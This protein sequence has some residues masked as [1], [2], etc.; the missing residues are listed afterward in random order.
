MRHHYFIAGIRSMKFK[1][2]YV[3]ALLIILALVV[4]VLMG[5]SYFLNQVKVKITEKIREMNHTGFRV[6]YD[7]MFINWKKN[8]VIIEKLLIQKDVYDTTCVDTEFISIPKLYIRGLGVV[9]A[10]LRHEIDIH[11]VELIEPHLVWR[12]N[13]TLKNDSSST[14]SKPMPLRIGELI[15][16]NF[17]LE[18]VDSATCELITG[19]TSDLQAT[20]FFLDLSDS[21]KAEWNA[22]KLRIG[23]STVQQPGS[24]YNYELHEANLNFVTGEIQIDSLRI[25]PTLSKVAFGRKIGNDLDRIDGVIPFIKL[26]NFKYRYSDSLDVAVGGAEVQFFFKIFHDKRLPHKKKYTLLPVQQIKQF[27]FGLTIDSLKV[28]KSFVSYEEIPPGG[29]EAGMVFFDDLYASVYHISNDVT[30]KKGIEMQ[31]QSRFMGKGALKVKSQFPWEDKEQCRISGA[32]QDFDL[33]EVNTMLVPAANVKIESGKLDELSFQFAY[34]HEKSNGELQLNYRDLKLVTY[35]EE[36]KFEKAKSRKRNK[37]KSE[38]ELK[39]DDVK[40]FLLNTFVIRKN[41]DESVPEEKRKGTI[42]FHRNTERSLF[43]YWWKS[44]S[45]GIKS[46]FHLDRVENLQKK[47]NA[48]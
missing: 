48:K 33:T 36:E 46:A 44:V 9:T 47:K 30:L 6:R 11:E 23:K 28:I 3:Y 15:A 10:I 5:R 20:G 18:Y 21:A 25:M 7:T 40:T 37:G 24:F 22:E 42:D 2:Q 31:A 14:D 1:K 38:D 13:T 12:N 16:R 43:N 17:K 4:A 8:E 32:L 19:V 41:M 45:S 26:T 35:K 34:D 39:K 27:G 29:E